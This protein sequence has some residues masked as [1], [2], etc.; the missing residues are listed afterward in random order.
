MG[1]CREKKHFSY[2]YS[3]VFVYTVLGIQPSLGLSSRIS[4]RLSCPSTIE[5]C[6]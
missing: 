5:L 4:R 2:F 6:P 1:P 3:E